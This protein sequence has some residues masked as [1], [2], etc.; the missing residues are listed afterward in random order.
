MSCAHLML[1]R[2]L[3][4]FNF[5]MDGSINEEVAYSTYTT[6]SLTQYVLLALRH[7]CINFTFIPSGDL[8]VNNYPIIFKEKLFL[9]PHR[10][11]CAPS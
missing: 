4:L 7:F 2:N 3:E 6:P 8:T 9:K 10:I 1:S 11:L 5:V